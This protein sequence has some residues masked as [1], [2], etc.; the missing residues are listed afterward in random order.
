MC[1]PVLHDDLNVQSPSANIA[2]Q[3]DKF[4]Y[5]FT[6][7]NLQMYIQDLCTGI[8]IVTGIL[9]AKAH[10]SYLEALCLQAF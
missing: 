8:L 6:L 4:V 1:G 2:L 5:R 9:I 10:L 3:A 7:L